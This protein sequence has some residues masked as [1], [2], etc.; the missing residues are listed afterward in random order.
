MIH[1]IDMESNINKDVDSDF[2]KMLEDKIIVHLSSW[3]WMRLYKQRFQY[4]RHKEVQTLYYWD[5]LEGTDKEKTQNYQN[6]I[7]SCFIAN[8]YSGNSFM[9]MDDEEDLDKFKMGLELN[10]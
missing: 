10:R 9:Y 2:Y 3:G 5:C 8:W 6:S 4:S 7:R 1:N